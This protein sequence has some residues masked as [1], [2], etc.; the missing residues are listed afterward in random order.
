M[1]PS[2]GQVS[3][4]TSLSIAPPFRTAQSAGLQPIIIE[5][6]TRRIVIFGKIGARVQRDGWPGVM[7]ARTVL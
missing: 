1:F 6:T 3:Y 4:H 7:S 5:G 2:T